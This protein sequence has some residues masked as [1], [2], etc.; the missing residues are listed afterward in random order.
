MY[1]IVILLFRYYWNSLF[2]F[3]VHGSLFLT[4]YLACPGRWLNIIVL[5][6]FFVSYF[7][8]ICFYFVKDQ[9]IFFFKSFISSYLIWRTFFYN[10]YLTYTYYVEFLQYWKLF[11]TSNNPKPRER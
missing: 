10:S 2:S 7:F 8:L 6:K 5:L 11:C 3:L 1:L 4:S 9:E